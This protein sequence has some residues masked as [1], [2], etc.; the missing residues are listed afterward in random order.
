MKLHSIACVIDGNI[1]KEVRRGEATSRKVLYDISVVRALRRLSCPVHLVGAVEQS[2]RTI[3]ELVRLQPGIVV[4]LAFSADPFEPSFAGALEMLGIPYTGSGPLGIGL[5]NDKVRSRRLLEAAGIPV[6]RFV[7]LANA[8]RPRKIDLA[9]P[10]IVKPVSLANSAGIHAD[11]VVDSYG[12]A[13]QRAD[14]I[15]RRFAV[16]AVCDE[17]IVG[18]EFQVCLVEVA[19]KVF[20][21]AAIVELHF[22]G[23]KPGTGF[24]SEAVRIKGKTRRVHRISLRCPSLSRRKMTE[25]AEIA[26]TAANVLELRGYAKLDLRMD[27]QE[28]IRVIEANAN[29]GIWSKSPLWCRPSFEANLRQILD[30]ALR[31]A[32]E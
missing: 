26:R 8:R 19:R 13:L 16:P 30:S 17:F 23:A 20:R 29:P 31:R 32:R 4:N 22:A 3:E 27:D 14:R 24:K 21:I 25:M 1:I 10:F 12:Q 6:P 28:R 15:W 2:A 5:A 11:S 9:P 7:E 18:R